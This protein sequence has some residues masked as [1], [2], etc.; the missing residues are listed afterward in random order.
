MAQPEIPASVCRRNAAAL[1]RFLEA[2][3]HMSPPPVVLVDSGAEP[4]GQSV[5]LASLI[6]DYCVAIDNFNSGYRTEYAPAVLFRETLSALAVAEAAAEILGNPVP[7]AIRA[8]EIMQRMGHAAGDMLELDAGVS[9]SVFTESLSS[10]CSEAIRDR[11]R[12]TLDTPVMTR[13]A[14]AG[15][16]MVVL[17]GRDGLNP[18]RSVSCILLSERERLDITGRFDAGGKLR[19]PGIL[20]IRGSLSGKAPAGTGGK[21]LLTGHIEVRHLPAPDLD[22]AGFDR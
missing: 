8:P 10:V 11:R 3:L 13:I 16:H 2:A 22:R 6:P 4:D 12:A 7:P 5:L 20:E 14:S 17:G 21:L 15:N 9:S 18:K 1:R 19:E